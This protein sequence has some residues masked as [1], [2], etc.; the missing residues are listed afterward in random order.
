MHNRVFHSPTSLAEVRSVLS[1]SGDGILVAGGQWIVPRLKSG[2]TQASHIV[3]LKNVSELQGIS[4]EA[5]TVT[6]GAC[7]THNAIARSKTMRSDLPILSTIAGQIGDPATRNLG[8][9]GGAFGSD[10]HRTDY[11]AAWVGLN[12]RMTTTRGT[13][14]AEEFFSSSEGSKL[15]DGEIIVSIA[16]Q[17]PTWAAFEKIP[18]PAAN[19]AEVGLF[20]CRLPDGSWRVV[21]LGGESGPKRLKDIET[22]LSEGIPN[23]DVTWPVELLRTTP[24]YVSRLRALFSRAMQGAIDE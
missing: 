5:Q 13:K 6:I 17:V 16:F 3:S 21:A 1:A 9:M 24:F 12:G 11:A 15:H 2:G 23:G 20:V 4:N 8:T 7:E 22:Q 10:P 19:Y 18:H 14:S